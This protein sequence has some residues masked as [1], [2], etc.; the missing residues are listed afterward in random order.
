MSLDAL[1][2]EKKCALKTQDNTILKNN[3]IKVYQNSS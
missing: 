1:K 2:R 3:N